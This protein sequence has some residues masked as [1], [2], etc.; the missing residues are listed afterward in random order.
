M[1]PLAMLLFISSIAL[2]EVPELELPDLAAELH[3]P[4]QAGEKA[5]AVVVFV[6][7]YCPTS[8]KLVPEVNEIIAAYGDRIKFSLVHAD[9]GVKSE[10]VQQHLEMFEVK[11]P[12]LLDREQKL[13]KALGVA[14]TPEVVVISK[15][16]M[17]VYQGRIN[18]LYLAATKRQ[19]QATVHDLRVA[20]DEVLAGKPVTVPRTEAV[21]C[22]LRQD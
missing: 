8:N 2:G 14:I 5:A 21:G 13:A 18:D 4:L 17:V 19:R 22:K 20:L 10:D 15:E 3:A 9:V 16:R 12:V 11:V 6:S 1:K 7:P